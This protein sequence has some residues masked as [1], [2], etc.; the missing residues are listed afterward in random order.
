MMASELPNWLTELP[1]KRRHDA[2]E[3]SEHENQRALGKLKPY[4]RS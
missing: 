2:S 4:R 3:G 1:N